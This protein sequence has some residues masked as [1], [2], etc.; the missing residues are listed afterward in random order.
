MRRIFSST[1]VAL[2][3]NEWKIHQTRFETNEKL[4]YTSDCT[5]H[6]TIECPIQPGNWNRTVE[7]ENLT[8]D[9]IH[10]RHKSDK[11]IVLPPIWWHS[12]PKTCFRK[13]QH[14]FRMTHQYNHHHPDCC[15]IF[16]MCKIEQ[17]HRD[18][19]RSCLM[20]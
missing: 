19:F 3:L 4:H 15:R 11:T 17:K 6:C 7:N 18:Q 2:N 1:V 8:F 10:T 13:T 14:H 20:N 9:T 12:D 16:A 5:P